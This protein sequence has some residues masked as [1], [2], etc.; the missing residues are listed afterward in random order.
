MIALATLFVSADSGLTDHPIAADHVTY[1]TTSAGQAWTATSDGLAPPAGCTFHQV[2]A[3]TVGVLA[4]GQLQGVRTRDECCARCWAEALCSAALHKSDEGKCLLAAKPRGA[5][6]VAV[7]IAEDSSPAWTR[8]VPQRAGPPLSLQ[9]PAVVPGDLLT[10][11]QNA[12]QIGDPNYEKTFL[13][14]SIWSAHTWTYATSFTLPAAAAA[15]ATA[16]GGRVLLV[17]DGV[18]APAPPTPRE[19]RAPLHCAM[20][21]R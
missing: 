17:F 4:S 3:P 11:L 21:S 1:L 12:G 10:D 15:A 19:P 8:C 5:K 20:A 7:S 16:A 9:I 2:E 14:A 18:K 6:T 13:N